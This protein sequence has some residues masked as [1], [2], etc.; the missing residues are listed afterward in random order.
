MAMKKSTR[1]SR[2]KPHLKKSRTWWAGFSRSNQK[3]RG[4]SKTNNSIIGEK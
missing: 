1:I 2:A 4:N 3:V